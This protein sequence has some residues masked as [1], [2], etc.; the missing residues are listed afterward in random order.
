MVTD[1]T[2]RI[3]QYEHDSPLAGDLRHALQDLAALPPST[4]IP[5]LTV[6]LD[7]QPQGSD[8]GREP[9][10]EPRRSER[11]SVHDVQGV[12]RRPARQQVEREAEELLSGYGPRGAAW[13]SLQADL[14]QILS[15]LD[16]DLNPAAQGVFIVACSAQDV[17]EALPLGLP[18][19]T[20]VTAGPTPALSQLT[21]LVEDYPAYAVL[22]ADQAEATLSV[23]SQ[24]T[25]DQ[26]LF[27]E[28][29]TYPRKQQQGGWSQRRFQARADERINAFA[30]DIAEE[31]H[32]AL[33][34]VGVGMLILAGDEVITSALDAAWHPTVKER[35]VGTLRLDITTPEHELIEAT[36]PVA[37]A[38]E[39]EREA[40]A[41]RQLQDAI[42]AA[43]PGAAGAVDTLMALQR[44]QVETL[45]VVDDFTGPG[46]ADYALS[47]SGVGAVPAEHPLGGEQ[48]ALV[49]IALEEEMVRL[50][51]QTGAEVQIIHTAVPVGSAE[52]QPIPEAG[53]PPP[54]T[55]AAEALDGL[56]GVGALLRFTLENETPTDSEA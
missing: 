38:A 7:W 39:R 3:R 13:E 5:Y 9:A 11:R 6:S 56:G 35:I 27:L 54:R 8:P 2:R 47:A 21:R 29:S 36:M 55:E 31:T 50:A 25:S 43:G 48:D 24:A 41:V 26:S 22:L 52:E 1:P 49:P 19:V 17:F 16:E 18:I 45:L 28:S 51:L 4:D 10:E 53:S 40:A 15:F 42:G 37:L 12:T 20:S 44:G 32:T 14:E 34:E 30:R 46:W 33:D 23:I